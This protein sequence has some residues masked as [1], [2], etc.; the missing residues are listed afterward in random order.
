[1][2]YI[3]PTVYFA[4]PP[5]LLTLGLAENSFQAGFFMQ[6]RLPL[7][8][9]VIQLYSLHSRFGLYEADLLALA[10]PKSQ[11]FPTLFV[12]EDGCLCR[13]G[14][15]LDITPVPQAPLASWKRGW[16]DNV[17]SWPHSFKKRHSAFLQLTTKSLW[18]L[19]RSL[20]NL[21]SDEKTTPPGG[22]CRRP[23]QTGACVTDAPDPWRGE[24]ERTGEPEPGGGLGAEGAGL[25]G[26]EGLVGTYLQTVLRHLQAGCGM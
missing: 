17:S 7:A 14:L 18:R 2:V 24:P 21:G 1:M 13:Q 4:I 11:E 12:F 22:E 10:D 15:L 23:E 16:D 19:W 25:E 6:L 5:N 3:I 20:Q 8:P 26:R 9:V